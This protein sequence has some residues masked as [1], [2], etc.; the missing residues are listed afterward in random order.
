[1]RSRT[2]IKSISWLTLGGSITKEERI[3]AVRERCKG[4]SDEG[5]VE[6]IHSKTPEAPDHIAAA[7]EQVKRRQAAT[8][9]QI[10][11]IKSTKLIAT[12]TLVVAIIT[13]AFMAFDK[14]IK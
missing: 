4:A 12:A 3:A 10:T 7:M 5:L 9:E 8:K 6:I 11:F 14:L 1:M 2:I 13:L